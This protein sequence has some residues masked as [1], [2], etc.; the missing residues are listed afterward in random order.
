MGIKMTL[1]QT[2]YGVCFQ[3]K[4]C[5]NEKCI[6]LHPYNSIIIC[7]SYIKNNKCNN[8]NCT[9]VHINQLS[10]DNLGKNLKSEII[11]K[12][13]I[14]EQN[15]IDVEIQRQIN[16]EI[17][18]KG[19]EIYSKK[20]ER[21]IEESI[22]PNKEKLSKRTVTVKPNKEKLS[23]RTVTVKPNKKICQRER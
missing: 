17:I 10:F 7:Y 11:Q 22:K 3:F 19:I 8:R 20:R 4:K 21:E 12:S 9:F 2:S 6:F 13:E 23:K 15:K 5:E 1:L 14:L 18:K 16:K